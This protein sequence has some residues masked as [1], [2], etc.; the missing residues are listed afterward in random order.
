LSP[1]RL[2]ALEVLNDATETVARTASPWLG[3]L[4]LSAL[5]ARFLQVYFYYQVFGLSRQSGQYGSYMFGLAALCMAAWLVLLLGRLVYIRACFM[6]QQ[7]ARP[8]G[9]EPLRLRSGETLV[10]LYTALLIEVG[11]HCLFLTFIFIPFFLVFGGIAA[12]TSY[13][14]EKAALFQPFKHILRVAAHPRVLLVN[15]FFMCSASAITWINLFFA[16]RLAAGLAASLNAGDAALWNHLLRPNPSFELVP[17]EALP[18]LLVLAG[19]ALAIEPIWLAA[20]VVFIHKLR[21][22]DTGDDLRQ[23][24]RSIRHTLETAA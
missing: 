21:A 19:A 9:L 3:V 2:S 23:W 13:G 10:F 11:F 14:Q 17:A 7:S 24:H 5:P 20:N 22:R 6:A 15:L 4:W 8:P 18:S 1:T 16:L 12:A